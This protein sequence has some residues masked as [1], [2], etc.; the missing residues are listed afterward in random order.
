[1][2]PVAQLEFDVPAAPAASAPVE[3]TQA[4]PAPQ[5]QVQQRPAA[6]KRAGRKPTVPAWEDVLLG[7]RTSGER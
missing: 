2:A 4:A 7:V 6:A 5:S 3:P 1:V